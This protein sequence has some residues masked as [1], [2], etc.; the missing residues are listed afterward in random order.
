M[1]P[2]QSTSSQGFII[3]LVHLDFWHFAKWMDSWSLIL[4]KYL[5]TKT[6]Q[7]GPPKWL[8]GKESACQ[9]RRWKRRRLDPWVRK[10]PWRRKWQ[11]APVYLA[12][13]I[14]WT[15][16]HGELQSMGLQSWTWL[17]EQ[18]CTHRS[19]EWPFWDFLQCALHCED[20]ELIFPTS[21]YSQKYSKSYKSPH[22]LTL[23]GV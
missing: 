22:S 23:S 16:E 18:A 13:K 1:L 8:S 20:H 12:W 14:L 5:N 2:L 15:E 7:L 17:S 10:I 9:C 3:F 19:T 21:M 6:G 4:S 11:P